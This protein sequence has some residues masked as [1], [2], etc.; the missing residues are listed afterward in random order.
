MEASLDFLKFVDPDFYKNK[1]LDIRGMSHT[2]YQFATVKVDKDT[3]KS[4]LAAISFHELMHL[5]SYGRIAL[6]GGTKE[7]YADVYFERSGFNI[8]EKDDRDSA[9]LFYLS[10]AVTSHFDRFFYEKMKK[11]GLFKEDLWE[12]RNIYENHSEVPPVLSTDK[13]E[14][15]EERFVAISSYDYD[16]KRLMRTLADIRKA[17]PGEFETDEQ[18]FDVFAR[19][20]FSG[21]LLEIARLLE[22]T[23]GKGAF[24]R[25]A[26]D[27]KGKVDF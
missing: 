5:F 2:F 3:S 10:E 22:K 12:I 25:A 24:R 7:G 11:S 16:H 21:K 13:D 23:Y 19:A 15:G 8:Y 14:S 26:E 17:N 27:T 4:Q 6:K 9:Y 18:V 20:H 1:K